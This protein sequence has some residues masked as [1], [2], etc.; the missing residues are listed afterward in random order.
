M[1]SEVLFERPGHKWVMIGRDPDRRDEIVDTNELAIITDGGTLLMDPG[2]IEIFPKVLSELTR[3]VSPGEVEV[4]FASHQDPDI[5]SSLPMWLDLCPDVKT[6]VSWIWCP[7]VSHFATG[8]DAAIVGIPDGGQT[9]SVGASLKVQAVPAHY[10]H[11]S[12]NFSLFD[13][14][15]RILF[16]GDIGSAFL[17]GSDTELFVED[18]DAHVEMM[19]SFHSRWMPSHAALT[20]WTQRVRA[21][22][23]RLIAPHHG[24]IFK[25]DDV[26]RLLDW[27]DG[28]DVGRLSAG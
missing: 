1:K 28:L 13:P 11:S 10:C 19:R 27:L 26:W 4:L 8:R 21:L 25:G 14:E 5:I 12:G 20:A 9:I 17:S 22:E 18:F 3:Y 2:G 7:Y 23:P 6:Y 15:A 24:R 16:S